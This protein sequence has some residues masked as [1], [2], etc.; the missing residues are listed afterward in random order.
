MIWK[1]ANPDCLASF[2][3]REGRFFRFRRNHGP[4]EIPPNAH[5]VWHFWLC[6]PCSEVYTLE[7][8]G[9]NIWLSP[10]SWHSGNHQAAAVRQVTDQHPNGSN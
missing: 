1:C 10:R 3:Y 7:A 9:E 6:Q 5:S 4:N 2:D 8:R